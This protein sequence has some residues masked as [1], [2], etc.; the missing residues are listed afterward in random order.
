MGS[1]SA[2][3]GTV[4]LVSNK[5]AASRSKSFFTVSVLS[6]NLMHDI[7]IRPPQS[8]NGAALSNSRYLQ[9][10]IGQ[11]VPRG[12]GLPSAKLGTVAVVSNTTAASTSKSLFM[13]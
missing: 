10:V 8:C 1:P 5:T 2:K 13:V 7:I 3:L 9:P 6:G 4:A 12:Y 11:D